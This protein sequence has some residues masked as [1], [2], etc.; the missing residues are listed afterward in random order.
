MILGDGYIGTLCTTLANFHKFEIKSKQKV[1]PQN[2]CSKMLNI[3]PKSTA[4]KLFLLLKSFFEIYFKQFN[5]T[6]P[7]HTYTHTQTLLY[8]IVDFIRYPK[9][10]MYHACYFCPFSLYF[11]LILFQTILI[12][13]KYQNSPCCCVETHGTY[14]QDVFPPPFLYLQLICLYC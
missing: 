13:V 8:T 11:P 6:L 2:T 10:Y 7:L 3:Y 14:C 5:D 12:L 1:I 4:N 9:L